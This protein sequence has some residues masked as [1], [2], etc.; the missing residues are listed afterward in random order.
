MRTPEYL[1]KENFGIIE[2]KGPLVDCCYDRERL[3]K[4]DYTFKPFP[5]RGKDVNKTY[6]LPSML[7]WN[8]LQNWRPEYSNNIRWDAEDLDRR[9]YLKYSLNTNRPRKV[10]FLPWYIS[11][12]SVNVQ[13][14]PRDNTQ[15]NTD[16]SK[17]FPLVKVYTSPVVGLRNRTTW[18][19]VANQ[20][21][22]D[23]LREL[24]E[25]TLGWSFVCI[26]GLWNTFGNHITLQVCV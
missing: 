21:H 3:F 19:E 25:T 6:S 4:I 23:D 2:D 9:V 8:G 17:I 16:S 10:G 22:E 18:L 7:R 26:S 11:F 5:L 20:H 14:R 15:R 24:F 12:N 13:I 1:A